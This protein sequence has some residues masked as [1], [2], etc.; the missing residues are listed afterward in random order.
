MEIIITPVK[1]RIRLKICTWGSVC[2][3]RV[4]LSMFVMGVAKTSMDVTI[5]A[6]ANFKALYQLMTY[7]LNSMMLPVIGSNCAGDKWVISPSLFWD[8]A[9]TAIN[10]VP[11]NLLP[12][13][14]I[15][16][17]SSLSIFFAS[18]FSKDQK[19]F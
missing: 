17:S 14:A 11:K 18:I 12:Q 15:R 5:V 8:R 1:V 7:R 9:N 13:P 16:A 4:A 19:K 6:G 10:S 3:T 2:V